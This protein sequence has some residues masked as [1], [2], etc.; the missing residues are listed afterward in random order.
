MQRILSNS[1]SLALTL[2]AFLVFTSSPALGKA[3]ALGEEGGKKE[4]SKKPAKDAG[5]EKSTEDSSFTVVQINDNV[6]VIKSAERASLQ[7][8][9]NDEYEAQ[10]K[11]FNEAQK[12]SAKDTK[13][14][15]KGA[16]DPKPTRPVFKVL[17][18]ALKTEADSNR[19]RDTNQKRIDDAKKKDKDSSKPKK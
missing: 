5:S 3:K 17:A 9:I 18:S 2:S 1:A 8:K 10:L 11:S 15:K 16:A 19:I 6:K 12:K 14:A 7:K 13:G 4:A